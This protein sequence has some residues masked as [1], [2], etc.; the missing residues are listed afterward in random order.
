MV[1]CAEA[2][3][4]LMNNAMITTSTTRMRTSMA[5]IRTT[6]LTSTIVTTITT[7]MVGETI[8]PPTGIALEADHLLNT[9]NRGVVVT[10]SMVTTGK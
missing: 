3:T 6:K 7:G 1:E 8:T 9:R 5:A 10:I 4:S 2:I